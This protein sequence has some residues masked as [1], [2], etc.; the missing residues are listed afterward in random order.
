MSRCFP[1]PP[2]GYEKKARNEDT[3]LLTKVYILS[4]QLTTIGSLTYACY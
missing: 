1:F 2:P 4:F 3:D